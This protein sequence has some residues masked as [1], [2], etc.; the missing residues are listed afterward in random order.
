MAIDITGIIN[1]NE[2]YT[3]HYLS[4]ILENDLKDIF[5]V[6]AN[7]EK[8]S[9]ESG[10][11]PKG[12][13]A[14]KLNAL[15]KSYFS[16]RDQIERSKDDEAVHA[17]QH[18]FF[19]KVFSALG[20][21]IDPELRELDT[22]EKV[23]VRCEI[24]KSSGAPDLWVLETAKPAEDNT[25]PLEGFFYFQSA[26]PGQEEMVKPGEETAEEIVTKKVFSLQEPPR[27]VI[28]YNLDSILLLDRS[29]WPEK[30]YLRFDLTEIFG[31]RS[32][33]TIKA[34]AALLCNDSI[35]PGD[36][37]P[38][39]DTLSEN[40]HKHAFA[41]SEDLK[42]SA[43][44]AIELLGNEAVW[45]LREVRKMGIFGKSDSS[46]KI[47]PDQLTRELLRYLYRLLFLFYIEAREELGYVPFKSPA[48]RTGYSLDRMELLPR[49][50]TLCASSIT[51]TSQ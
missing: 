40:S 42:Y 36:D 43:R 14:Q 26:E 17:A 41:V 35:S 47:D 32:Q 20:Y 19:L 44:E 51:I 16:M 12:S 7:A 1:E 27:W 10:N 31:R 9:G 6:W 33:S 25:D 37:I 39:L 34:M 30:R 22:G 5:S 46:E 23:A 15:C 38:L 29:K 18:E 28:L 3:H 13:P 45:Y 24:R 8:E 21:E 48:Y 11:E 2:F 50:A 4:A 49:S